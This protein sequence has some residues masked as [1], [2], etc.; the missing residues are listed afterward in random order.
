[1]GVL[2]WIAAGLVAFLV[3]RIV[4]LLR[5]ASKRGE[6]ALALAAGGGAGVAAT[7]LDFGGWGVLDWRA[8]LFAFL[9]AVAIVGAARAFRK[10]PL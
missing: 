9:C 1:M 8:G 3:A 7:A 6:L 2:L 10:A 4:P 5:P